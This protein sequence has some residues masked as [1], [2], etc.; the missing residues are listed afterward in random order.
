MAVLFD[1]ISQQLD[2]SSCDEDGSS[3]D[4]S[5]DD[6]ASDLSRIRSPSSVCGTPRVQ[7]HRSRSITL[8]SPSFQPANPIP[9]AAWRK[10]RLCESPSTPKVEYEPSLTPT[11]S[12]V[13]NVSD[14]LWFCIIYPIIKGISYVKP[15]LFQSYKLPFS[16]PPCRVC[17]LSHPSLAP[18]LREVAAKGPCDSPRLLEMSPRAAWH[19]RST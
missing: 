9:Y 1:G 12:N 8:S 14:P 6:C 19:P 4:N 3:S 2:F 16:F 10:L 11:V 13:I 7:R 5:W 18:A 17:C 15:V